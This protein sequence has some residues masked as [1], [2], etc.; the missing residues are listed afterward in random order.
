MA[1]LA[2]LQLALVPRVQKV[3]WC[4][5]LYWG[6]LLLSI[7]NIAASL[8]TAIRLPLV[9]GPPLNHPIIAV[10]YYVFAAISLAAFYSLATRAK[11]APDALKTRITAYKPYA[12]LMWL[13][14]IG[15]FA[16]WLAIIILAGANRDKFCS[17]MVT[18]MHNPGAEDRCHEAYG[19]FATAV[20]V[21]MTIMQGLRYLNT[22]VAWSYYGELLKDLKGVQPLANQHA[23]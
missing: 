5:P 12:H 10:Y 23:I 19:L 4:I 11:V 20:I 13:D 14:L 8:I 17:W 1:F 2:K 18:R 16:F 7:F 21:P 6:A 15:G 22:L 9:Y 3:F